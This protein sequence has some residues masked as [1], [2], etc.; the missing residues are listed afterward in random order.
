MANNVSIIRCAD[1]DNE[2]VFNAVREAVDAAGGLDVAG[3]SVLLKPNM[4]ATADPEGAVTSRP[5]FLRAAIR[6]V[7][8]RGASR[9]L[10]GDSPAVQSGDSV[11]QKSGLKPVALDEGAEW[12]DFNDSVEVAVPEGRLV[13]R[14]TMAKAVAETD[15]VISLCRLKTHSFMYFTGAVKNMFGAIPGLQKSAFHLRFP[16]K[17]E[18]GVMLADLMLA[19]KPSYALM[20]AIVGMEGPGPRNGSPRQIGV[21]LAG[22]NAF[23]VDWVASSL[24]GYKP[25][26]IPYLREAAADPVYG[27]D[28][29][30]IEHRGVRPEQARVPDFKLV[31]IVVN[32]VPKSKGPFGRLIRNLTVPRPFFSRERCVLCGACVKIC[33]GSALTIAAG[34]AGER[35]IAVEYQKCVR[36]YCCHEVCPEDAIDL[37]R[38]P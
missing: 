25:L 21:V 36:C 20:D 37:R 27:F 29:D 5:E 32:D 3:K 17:H 14:F 8:E 11:G 10:V 24:V 22:A 16:G 34:R 7:R 18:F 13:K 15:C 35:F 26:D 19:V 2:A 23:A 6:L 28:P 30:S 9:I 4:L 33:P 31:P 38:R 1:Y 12:V